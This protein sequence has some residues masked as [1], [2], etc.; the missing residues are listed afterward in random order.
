MQEYFL[1]DEDL[2]EILPKVQRSGITV[3]VPKVQRSGRAVTQS[4]NT[5]QKELP[6]VLYNLKYK[7]LAELLP[8][9]QRSSRTNIQSAKI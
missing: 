6:T 3:T 9:V 2:A 8:E 1:K 5:W 4:I 7:D